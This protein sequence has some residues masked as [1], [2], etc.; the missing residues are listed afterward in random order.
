[1]EQFLTTEELAK[2]WRMSEKTL[3]NWR[4]NNNG[5]DYIKVGSR[6]LYP[7]AGV[8]QFERESHG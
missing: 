6:V 8:L 4:C 2:R 1:M 7:L 3:A 5:P